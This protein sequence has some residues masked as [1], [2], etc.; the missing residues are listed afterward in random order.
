[1]PSHFRSISLHPAMEVRI[2]LTELRWKFRG[3]KS[4]EIVET[5]ERM[6]CRGG[7]QID[8]T[9]ADIAVAR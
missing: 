5:I 7:S 3:W 1:M 6:F 9:D 2:H 4:G 8:P